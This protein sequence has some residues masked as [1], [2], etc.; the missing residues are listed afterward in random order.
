M[1]RAIKRLQNKTADCGVS[2]LEVLIAIAVI[3]ISALASYSALAQ[4]AQHAHDLEIRFYALEVAR[5]RAEEIK[6]LGV[7]GARALPETETMGP[8]TWAIS[9][10]EAETAVGLIE[11]EIKVQAEDQPGAR[12]V[13]FMPLAPTQ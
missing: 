1:H 5:N 12:L 13:T 9:L 3:S 10:K 2:T 4:S 7:S 8:V 11:V 6:L